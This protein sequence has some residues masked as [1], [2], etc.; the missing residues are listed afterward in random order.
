VISR[1][2]AANCKKEFFMKKNKINLLIIALVAVVGFS[3]AACGDGDGGSYSGGGGYGGGGQQ[4]RPN[5]P[6]GVRASLSGSGETVTISWNSV[7]DVNTYYVYS[8][9]SGTLAGSPYSAAK[10]E[11]SSNG[12][13]VTLQWTW[14]TVT[15]RYFYVTSSN[16]A[17]ESNLSYPSSGVVPSTGGNIG[18]GSSGSGT[19]TVVL[20][21]ESTYAGDDVYAEISKTSNNELVA[22]A[23]IN[24]GSTKTWT[25]IPTGVSLTVGV[26][27]YDYNVFQSPSFTL[28]SGQT[29]TLR[30]D[31]LSVK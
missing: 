16:S 1:L 11:S 25:N 26:V 9:T 31:G 28:S 24:R 10:Y 29:K 6:T 5:A 8:S 15:T 12:T 19:G 20:I 22:V 2:Q 17:G 13:S 18:G 21:N 14:D 27:D 7:Y 23:Y 3:M 4:T 30:Y